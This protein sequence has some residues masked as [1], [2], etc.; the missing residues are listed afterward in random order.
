MCHPLES[1]Y[2]LI[3]SIHIF[4]GKLQFYFP[5]FHTFSFISLA[6]KPQDAV[7]EGEDRYHPKLNVI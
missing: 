1:L 3:D 7:F 2:N 4:F 5:I 6:L